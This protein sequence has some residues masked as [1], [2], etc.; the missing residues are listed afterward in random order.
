[1][2]K[3]L[4]ALVITIV[5]ILSTISSSP[6]YAKQKED[7]ANKGSKLVSSGDFTI[8]Y[9]VLEP[10]R[11][12]FADMPNDWSTQSING[13]IEKGLL[14][15]FEE[16]GQKLIRPTSYTTRAQM[17]TILNRI[18]DISDKADL[19]G[20]LDIPS[21]SWYADVM[22]KAAHM[23]IFAK[24]TYMRPN[25]NITREEAMTVIVRAF[26]IKTET[27]YNIE[28]FKDFS[29]LASWAIESV[30]VLAANGYIQGNNGYLNPKAYMTR[31]ELCKLLN[32]VLKDNE[33]ENLEGEKVI[34]QPKNKK[35]SS[36][37]NSDNDNNNNTIIEGSHAVTETTILAEGNN[38][39]EFKLG[40][41]YANDMTG[42]ASYMMVYSVKDITSV[43]NALKDKTRAEF[44]DYDTE[45]INKGKLITNLD[46]ADGAANTY[47]S[48]QKDIIT[49]Q[50]ITEPGLYHFYVLSLST[51]GLIGIA[52]ANKTIDKKPFPKD[53]I[54]TRDGGYSLENY[55]VEFNTFS[56]DRIINN[57]VFYSELGESNIRKLVS[58]LTS[59]QIEELVNS[60]KAIY[61]GRE[62][63]SGVKFISTLKDFEGNSYDD[64]KIYYIYALAVSNGGALGLSKADLMLTPANGPAPLTNIG[65]GK[66]FVIPAGGST[67]LN[68]NSNSYVQGYIDAFKQA[69]PGITPRVAVF[70]TSSGA[71]STMYDYFYNDGDSSDKVVLEKD[72]CEAV[73]IP[74]GI[75]N[76]ESITNEKYFADLVKS[77]HIVLLMGG[78]QA[79]HARA[80]TNDDGSL[81]EVGKAIKYVF[82]IG[83]TIAGTSAGAQVLSDPAFQGGGNGS[84]EAMFWNDTEK[85][86][87]SDYNGKTDSDVD[88][89]KALNNIAYNSTGY[90][91]L[92]A[93]RRVL[94]DT[95]FDARGRLGRLL[96]A[97]RDTN[98]G[99]TTGTAIG[100]DE[101]TGIRISEG[102][103]IGTVFG[104]G[105]VF[106]VDADEAVWDT[107]DVFGVSNIKLNYLTEG[108]TYNFDSKEVKTSKNII[109]NFGES[110][111]IKENAFGT[112]QVSKILLELAKSTESK[113]VVPVI[114][115]AGTE[116]ATGPEFE[117]T[118]EKVGS[119]ICYSSDDDYSNGSAGAN[120]GEYN[121]TTI[122]NIKVSISAKE[123]TPDPLSI[124]GVFTNKGYDAKIEF[125][126][127]LK[128]GFSASKDYLVDLYEEVAEDYITLKRGDQTL[129]QDIDASL[130]ILEENVLRIVLDENEGDFQVGDR[131]VI[132]TN[133]EDILGQKLNEELVYVLNTDQQWV[134]AE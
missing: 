127:N 85:L 61:T 14:Q 57:I 125:N 33:I 11:S 76:Y 123:S 82:N 103:H 60:N 30:R 46:Y 20:V 36:N 29:E 100:L 107:G 91:D 1:M 43:Y 17:A 87:M 74:L 10:T 8:K 117:V 101:G 12:E 70:E 41:R 106:I 25:D 66:G 108:D 9:K 40:F 24:D 90:V 75:D 5:M 62:L 111:K 132:H 13:C 112:Y 34:E 120:L 19:S 109:V 7:V 116:F 114:K 79:K 129:V 130:C 38:S 126:N 56:D 37:N 27:N 86:D 88:S 2:K 15:G 71:E 4:I 78:D 6:I 39:N 128:V 45:E 115:A 133:I 26:S 94:L 110:I 55:G 58:D 52:E 102:T 51:D 22:S 48:S 84:Y 32:V 67:S 122:D 21:D 69:T 105:G 121:K 131:I 99:I 65:T 31:A 42:V 23:G 63:E 50:E 73:Y 93:G 89:S 44:D 35:S 134:I 47:Y 113:I 98:N 49:N 18:F 72:G 118:F 64:E 119:T 95:H 97:L 53:M 68:P 83:G 54:A 59:N 80:L 77:C 28:K 104:N 96:V 3:R 124:I 16:N 92:A 81:T